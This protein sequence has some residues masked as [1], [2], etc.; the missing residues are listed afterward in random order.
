MFKHLLTTVSFFTECFICSVDSS[1][2]SWFTGVSPFP[3]NLSCLAS[4]TQSFT[5]VAP[6]I[7]PFDTIAGY[8]PAGGL[9]LTNLTITCDLSVQGSTIGFQRTAGHSIGIDRFSCLGKSIY[10]GTSLK[11]HLCIIKTTS[12]LRPL[13]LVPRSSPLKTMLNQFRIKTTSIFRTKI[14]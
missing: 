6:P 4:F 5:C 11:D 8:S 13:Y 14:T 2:P 1:L 3:S 7:I 10:S 12:I 9:K